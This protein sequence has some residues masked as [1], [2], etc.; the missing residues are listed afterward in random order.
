MGEVNDVT[1]P[2][3]AHASE[4]RAPIKCAAR[5]SEGF[6]ERTQIKFLCPC[7][8]MLIVQLPVTLRYG[9]RLQQT[10]VASLL[11]ALRRALPQTL[12]IDTPINHNMRHMN[13]L[14]PELT[15]KGLTQ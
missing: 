6:L 11:Y 5:C 13:A 1:R 4:P 15:G 12:A 10:V 3:G 7:A 9:A 8:S 14:G 2:R